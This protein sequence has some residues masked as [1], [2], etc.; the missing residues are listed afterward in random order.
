MDI[1]ALKAHGSEQLLDA[2]L[3]GSK[4]EREPKRVRPFPPA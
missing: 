2:G 3:V 1:E 4:P